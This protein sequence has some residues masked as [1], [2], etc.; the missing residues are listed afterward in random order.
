MKRMLM[1]AVLLVS[2][3]AA[4]QRP[5]VDSPVLD[6]LVGRWV[7]QGTIA[8]KQTTHDITAEWVANHQYLHLHEISREKTPAGTPQYDAF[9]LIGWDPEKKMY[10]IIFLDNFWNVG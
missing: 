4:A 7:L 8:G 6:H 5:P 1:F 2:T 9:I 3:A 10:P